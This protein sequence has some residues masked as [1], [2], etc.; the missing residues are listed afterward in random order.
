MFKDIL[1][2]LAEGISL[3][4]K[5]AQEAMLHIMQGQ[6]SESQIAAYLMGLRMKGETVDEIVGSVKAM[7]DM[8]VRIH[9]G[10]PLVV[11][12]CGTGGDRAN[13]FNISTAAAFVVA[14]GGMSLNIFFIH[15][16]PRKN[17]VGCRE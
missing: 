17:V 2:T 6:A 12:T 1:N 9:I 5:Q 15:D 10:D 11:D 4:E 13:T 14:G 16:R 8:A 3:S 7:R